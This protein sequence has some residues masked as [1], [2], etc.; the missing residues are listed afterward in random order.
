MSHSDSVFSTVRKK[1]PLS[2]CSSNYVD[3]SYMW[4][5]NREILSSIAHAGI[6]RLEPRVFIPN[7]ILAWTQRVRKKEPRE[8]ILFSL[9]SPHI[10]TIRSFFLSSLSF[11]MKIRLEW[12]PHTC[13]HSKR[14]EDHKDPW[15]ILRSFI[16]SSVGTT[17][18]LAG[19]RRQ[20]NRSQGAKHI[21]D[22]SLSP[23]H[24][25]FHL[26]QRR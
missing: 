21:T 18:L 20:L 17:S 25:H 14:K 19:S 12:S 13:T 3:T 8:E 10:G 11:T 16:C 24:C 2:T 1:E 5:L 7:S 9:S 23:S 22:I 4:Y 6:I 26:F 15:T